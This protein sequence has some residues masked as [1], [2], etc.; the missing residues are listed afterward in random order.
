[1]ITAENYYEETAKIEQRTELLDGEMIIMESPG[2][3]HQLL[4]GGFISTFLPFTDSHKGIGYAIAAVDVM[5]DEFNIVVPDFIVTCD[6]QKFDE[7]KHNGAP[8][9]VAEIVSNNRSN[10]YFHKL[11]L[12]QRSGVREYWIV[13]PMEKNIIVYTDLDQEKPYVMAYTFGDTVPV[14]ICEDFRIDFAEIERR[15]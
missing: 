12:Y 13:N 8:D 3:R 1:M 9:F 10:D 15:L 11:W 2:L 4:L 6:P 5:L 14:G 7:Q